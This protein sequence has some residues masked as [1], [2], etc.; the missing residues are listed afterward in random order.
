MPWTDFKS[1]TPSTKTNPVNVELSKSEQE[2][3]NLFT[4]TRTQDALSKW[5]QAQ[6]KDNLQAIDGKH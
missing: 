4:T 2:A 5:T 6:F 1:A 3:K